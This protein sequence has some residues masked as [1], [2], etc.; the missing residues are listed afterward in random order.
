MSQVVYRPSS[1]YANT[2]QTSW[3]LDTYEPREIPRDGTDTL[4][5][6]ATRYE[7][8]PDLLSYDLYGTPNFWW[9]FMIL[10]PNEIKDPIYDFKV[11]LRIYTP[12][13]N[14]LTNLL[15]V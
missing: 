3:Y 4:R 2:P 9:I 13:M 10:N 6:L 8:R 14:R 7:L 11:G 1:P 15:G 5:V 12:T